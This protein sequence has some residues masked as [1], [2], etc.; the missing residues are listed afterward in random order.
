MSSVASF[1][2]PSAAQIFADI[3]RAFAEDLG[4]TE[5]SSLDTPSVDRGGVDA[6]ATLLPADASAHAELTCRESAIIA[7][8]PWFEACFRRMDPDVAIEWHTEDGQHV[9]AGSVICR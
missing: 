3:E 6:T 7:G 8:I 9:A 5:M 1:D 2:P 4:P